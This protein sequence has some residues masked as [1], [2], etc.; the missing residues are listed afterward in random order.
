[1]GYKL[2]KHADRHIKYSSGKALN[3]VSPR[4][5]DEAMKVM[6]ERKVVAPTNKD[7]MTLDEIMQALSVMPA[8]Q[9]EIAAR[10]WPNVQR[11]MVVATKKA[12]VD[13]KA[14]AKTEELEKQA[15]LEAR[16]K[17][18]FKPTFKH[19]DVSDDGTE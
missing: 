14:K 3:G 13:A 9:R 4:T 11:A 1:M 7:D 15:K 5:D 17:E 2:I 8:N 12:A 19:I 10:L 6:A 16:E 18:G